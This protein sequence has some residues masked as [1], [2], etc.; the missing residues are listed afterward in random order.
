MRGPSAGVGR[1]GWRGWLGGAGRGGVGGGVLLEEGD[2]LGHAILEDLKA[3]FIEGLDGLAMLVSDD[4]VD[5][6]V[7][8]FLFEGDDALILGGVW[9]LNVG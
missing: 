6:D 5:Y 3:G 9:G 8:D 7:A 4:D 2:V 1:E